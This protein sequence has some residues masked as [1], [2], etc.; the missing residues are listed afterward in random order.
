MLRKGD[1]KL[2]HYVGFPDELFNLAEDPEELRN[3]A[4]DPDSAAKLA[5]LHAELSAIC[6]PAATDAQAFA[7]QASLVERV[8]GRDAALGLGAPGATPPPEMAK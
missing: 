2:I 3:L 5:E 1:W 7:D 8:G 4:T 6:D